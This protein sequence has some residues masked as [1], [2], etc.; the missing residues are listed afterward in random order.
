MLYAGIDV[1]AKSVKAALFDGEKIVGHKLMVTE[2]EAD[3]A[4]H[5][6]YDMLLAELGFNH[7]KWRAFA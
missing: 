1:G 4:A 6:V 5:S 3:L 7:G 2:D